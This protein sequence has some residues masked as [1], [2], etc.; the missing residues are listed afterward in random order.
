MHYHHDFLPLWIQSS[1]QQSPSLTLLTGKKKGSVYVLEFGG[2]HQPKSFH[3]PITALDSLDVLLLTLHQ[4]RA[5]HVNVQGLQ[6]YSFLI[7]TELTVAQVMW[8]GYRRTRGWLALV[9]SARTDCLLQQH[10]YPSVS[11]A[12]NHAFC[13]LSGLKQW[14]AQLMLADANLV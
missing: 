3:F 11:E 8:N 12:I 1:R 6:K 7:T 2:A 13:I 5:G 10:N 9:S 14:K 4:P